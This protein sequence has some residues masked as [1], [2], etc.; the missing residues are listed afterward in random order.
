MEIGK[1]EFDERGYRNILLP[2]W[3][4]GVVKIIWIFGQYNRGEYF[5]PPFSIFV[6]GIWW[7]GFGKI[8]SIIP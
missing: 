4:E 5:S 8:L 3:G 2:F 1:G 6:F 7:K